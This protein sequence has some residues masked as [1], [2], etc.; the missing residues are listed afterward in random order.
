[1]GSPAPS[2]SVPP[3]MIRSKLMRLPLRRP[4]DVL[5]LAVRRERPAPAVAADAGALVAAEGRVGIERAA[6]HLHR[7]AAERARHPQRTLGVAGPHVA[8]EAVIRVVGERD[9]LR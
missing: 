5:E 2:T 7:P 9:R 3:L 1:M 8:V 4:P 6:V